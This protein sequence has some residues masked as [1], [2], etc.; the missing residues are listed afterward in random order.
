MTQNIDASID[1]ALEKLERERDRL[2]QDLAIIRSNA[3]VV[4]GRLEVI[5]ADLQRLI[6][7]RHMLTDLSGEARKIIDEG[8]DVASSEDKEQ[9]QTHYERIIEYLKSL[10]NEPQLVTTIANETSIQRSS[11]TAVLYRTHASWFVKVNV[12]DPGGAVRW[13]YRTA[14]DNKKQPPPP[15]P[16]DPSDD[17]P[18]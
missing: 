2:E 4:E 13:R 17:I 15:P 3:A 16:R 12:G 10:G 6:G 7:A 1:A 14:L 18:F 11:V 9:N 5:A 8:G